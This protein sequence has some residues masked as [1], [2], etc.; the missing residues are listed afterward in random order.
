MKSCKSPFFFSSIHINAHTYYMDVFGLYIYIQGHHIILYMC[1][2]MRVC[3]TF[4]GG[5]PRAWRGHRTKWVETKSSVTRAPERSSP[6]N[7]KTFFSL[8]SVTEEFFRLISFN[9]AIVRVNFNYIY[10]LALIFQWFCCNWK[11]KAIRSLKR[12]GE[13]TCCTT[14]L[15]NFQ[16]INCQSGACR[17]NHFHVLV[18]FFFLFVHGRE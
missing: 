7:M 9:W 15:N 1:G 10:E 4:E 6:N 16:R 2:E 5:C 11:E 17:W 8:T 13:R 12:R 3:D 18:F 14:F